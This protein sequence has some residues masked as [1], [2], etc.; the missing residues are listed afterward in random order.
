M[1]GLEPPAWWRSA[2]RTFFE[3]A[4]WVGMNTILICAPSSPAMSSDYLPLQHPMIMPVHARPAKMH[5]H[6]HMTMGAAL[7]VSVL[8]VLQI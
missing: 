4:R 6:T 1:H 2:L 5:K 8:L 7:S 3:P